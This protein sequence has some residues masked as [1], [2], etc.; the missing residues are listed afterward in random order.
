MDADAAARLRALAAT[1]DGLVTLAQAIVHGVK[2]AEID[3]EIRAHR[4]TALIRGVYLLDPD[5]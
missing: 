1:Q 4:W 2:P 3:S 5:L